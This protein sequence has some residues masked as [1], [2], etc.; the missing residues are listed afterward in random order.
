[1]KIKTL[2]LAS[3]LIAVA[4]FFSFCTKEAPLPEQAPVET[5]SDE[6]AVSRGACKVFVQATNGAVT[7]CG[8]QLN[9]N[10]CNGVL[11]DGFIA[12]G[13]NASYPLA[14]PATLFFTRSGVTAASATVTVTTS[15]GPQTYPLPIVGSLQV[16]IGNLCNQF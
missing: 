12:N 3:S 14:T 11:G 6:E 2:L 5:N 9:T 10:P 15:T 8:T 4:A 13:G 16:N 7:V 1:M